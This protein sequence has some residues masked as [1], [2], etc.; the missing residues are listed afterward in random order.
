MP[1]CLAALLILKSQFSKILKFINH[2]PLVGIKGKNVS[3][4]SHYSLNFEI[5]SLKF[6]LASCFLFFFTLP[7]QPCNI[8]I[9]FLEVIM[10]YYRCGEEFTCEMNCGKLLGCGI[11]ACELKCHKAECPPCNRQVAQTCHCGKKKRV[12]ICTAETVGIEVYGCNEVCGKFK[13]CGK[14]SCNE[15]CHQGMCKKCDLEVDRL[16]TCPCGKTDLN[17]LYERYS[18][19]K[20]KSCLDPVP[21]CEMICNAQLSCGDPNNLHKCQSVCHTGPCS[22]CPE[23][24]TLKCRCGQ[25]DRELMCSQLTGR[26]DDV[27]CER[28]CQKKRLCGRHKCGQMCCIDI[29]HIC[30]MICGRMLSCK[31]HR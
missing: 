10:I 29:D 14:H 28:R 18:I 21:T 11:H 25:M 1:L 19:E 4:H 6:S 2:T 30:M 7:F 22:T 9:V 12:L 23:T 16:T 15:L 8:F 31:L 13:D 27:R 24:T 20:R 3:H 17:V 5:V 26:P